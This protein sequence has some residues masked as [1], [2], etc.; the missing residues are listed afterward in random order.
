VARPPRSPWDASG[1]DEAAEADAHY[2]SYSV[3]KPVLAS[4]VLQVA[5]AGRID[6]DAPLAQW[7]P[8]APHV[9][10]E[11]FQT[12]VDSHISSTLALDIGVAV[13]QEDLRR[14]VPRYSAYVG[15]PAEGAASVVYV[16]DVYHPGLV[17]HGVM[18]ATAPTLAALIHWV[19]AADFLPRTFAHAFRS[20]QE[21][22]GIERRG[23]VS[24][25]YG[26]GLM[27][28]A[29]VP[30]SGSEWGTPLKDPG[31]VQRH[32]TCGSEIGQG[33]RWQCSPTSK[34]QTTSKRSHTEGTLPV[35]NF[36]DSG[37]TEWEV[38]QVRRASNREGVV[39]P[40]RE[41]GWLSFS[42]GLERRRLAPFP[43]DWEALRSPELQRL[44]EKAAVVTSS[45]GTVAPRP[46]PAIARKSAEP[47]ITLPPDLEEAS[48][49]LA[50]SSRSS[51]ETA[52]GGM[53]ALRRLMAERGIAPET[54]EFR[55]ARRAFISAYYFERG[56][57]D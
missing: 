31:T 33:R 41:A 25:A 51:G 1:V 14:L 43:D 47:V 46:R 2:V 57:T 29:G 10:D 24:P 36:V 44:C 3:T 4:L 53:M 20:P 38:F 40:G 32:L 12:I 17:A 39:T 19:C 9:R 50:Q 28:D 5:A 54:P 18:T 7:H 52:I 55:A 27:M 42:N 15:T 8:N 49:S 48:R 26:L 37:G 30:H 35:V 11:S 21:I 6:L 23:V 22:S 16:R 56:T 34:Q 13:T 45:D